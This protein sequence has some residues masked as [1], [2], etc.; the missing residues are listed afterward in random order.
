MQQR[1]KII[2]YE[3]KI[4]TGRERKGRR[5]RHDIFKEGY[6]LDTLNEGNICL[7][8]LGNISSQC[9][10]EEYLTALLE[11]MVVHSSTLLGTFQSRS[12]Y[13]SPAVFFIVSNLNRGE[14]EKAK[15]T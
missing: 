14:K 4:T 10:N 11:G 15:E 3:N 12:F 13:T 6:C 5:T 8:I 9:L 2:I 7:H 1:I